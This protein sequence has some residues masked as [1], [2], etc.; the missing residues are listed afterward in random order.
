MD[1]RRNKIVD[2]LIIH[3]NIPKSV[4]KLIGSYDYYLEGKKFS[5]IPLCYD[6]TIISTKHVVIRR[7]YFNN[8]PLGDR[9]ELWDMQTNTMEASFNQGLSSLFKKGMSYY[10]K[11]IRLS[12]KR[13]V[14]NRTNKIQ[15]WDIVNISGKIFVVL[16]DQ[17]TSVYC[18]EISLFELINDNHIVCGS[19]TNIDSILEVWNLNDKTCEYILKGSTGYIDCIAALSQKQIACGLNEGNLIVWNVDFACISSNTSIDILPGNPSVI[20]I[21][22]GNPSVI[23]D[24]I[25]STGYGSTSNI[26]K[27]ILKTNIRSIDYICSCSKTND[28]TDKIL[29]WSKYSDEAQIWNLV[30]E[31]C[32]YSFGSSLHHGRNLV[33]FPDKKIAC[34][35]ITGGRAYFFVIFDTITK[36]V[37][38]FKDDDGYNVEWC[39][40]VDD[41]CNLVSNNKVISSLEK[42]V[43]GKI[44]SAST[45]NKLEVWD[46]MTRKCEMVFQDNCSDSVQKLQVL[47]NE[48][49]ISLSNYD[50]LSLWY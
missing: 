36:E 5:E 26:K 15:L 40:E 1:Q 32:D 46:P 31:T 25:D 47:D 49:I 21:L 22:P 33:V 44:I 18:G 48:K 29:C 43:D 13:F 3:N 4:A 41:D 34:S 12:D 17:I 14:I 45:K 11:C 20:D 39:Y 50:K 42:L 8:S 24:C 2:H 6:F 10:T 9:Y 23:E 19:S 16:S 27:I 37:T 28:I 7:D 38:N 30:T 35:L